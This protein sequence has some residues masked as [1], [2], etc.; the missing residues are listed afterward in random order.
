MCRFARV[1]LIIASEIHGVTAAVF[2]ASV[3]PVCRAAPASARDLG[4]CRA[5]RGLPA[6]SAPRRCLEP[7][8]R[9]PP[10][11]ANAPVFST[12]RSAPRHCRP[13][14]WRTNSRNHGIGLGH[15]TVEVVT[16]PL[17][18]GLRRAA[19]DLGDVV[20]TDSNPSQMTYL[21]AYHLI[22]EKRFSSHRR[23]LT[24]LGPGCRCARQTID[25]RL[26]GSRCAR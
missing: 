25:P 20:L 1:A 17:A 8:C 3:S 7:G 24:Y 22:E 16:T 13:S 26:D 19:D 6:G 9:I 10:F 2:L 5:A 15:P 18:Q 14:R 11:R 21:F 12:R 23:S 4:C